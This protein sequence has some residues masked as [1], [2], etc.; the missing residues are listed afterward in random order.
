[1]LRQLAAWGI[2][3]IFGVT[4]D[5]LLPLLSALA[6][7]EGIRYIGAA[8]E[9]GAAFMASY[10]AKLT[11]KL[12]VCIASAAGAVHLLS[13]LADAF[14]DGAPV[15]ALTGQTGTK[16][17]GTPVKQYFDQ[18]QLMRNF[19]AS[20]EL[21]IQ[22]PTG[23][24]LLVRAMSQALQQKTVTHLSVPEDLW[25]APVDATPGPQPSLLK[26]KKQ[27]CFTGDQNHVTSLMQQS[28][29][30]LLVVGQAAQTAL[31]EVTHLIDRWQ[32]A[33]IIAQEA[34]G[35]IADSLP[36][37]LG[38]IGQGWIPPLITETDCILLLGDTSYEDVFLPAV[39]VIQLETEVSRIDDRYLWNSLAGD[40]AHIL[41]ILTGALQ[42]YKPDLS[43]LERQKAVKKQWNEIIDADRKDNRQPLSPARL[44]ADLAPLIA[45]D[46]IISLDIGAFMHWF[47]R[48]FQAENQRILLSSRWRNMGAALPAAVGAKL[49]YPDKQVVALVGDGG[50]LMSMGELVTAVKY[51][52]P[53]VVLIVNNQLYGLEKDKTIDQK[54]TPLGLGIPAI[55]YHLYAQACGARGFKL[56]NPADLENV[57]SQAIAAPGPAVINVICRDRRLPYPAPGTPR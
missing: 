57:F 19:A 5:D 9:N 23:L 41:K 11:G 53:L 35:I 8:N 36:A 14:M 24:R 47:D 44:M 28:R 49:L 40:L 1:M 26:V 32:P 45:P 2:R 50:F 12:G 39:P 13:G 37:V 6:H 20:S 52:L 16:K 25:S 48:N 22:A 15:L 46:A 51:K 7:E 55:D 17:I 29:R 4:G 31:P 38:G 43:W 54:L 30:P 10:Q 33:V 18:Q 27:D 42:D 21:I 56:E 34:K 3:Y